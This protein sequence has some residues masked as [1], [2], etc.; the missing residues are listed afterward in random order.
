MNK[1]TQNNQIKLQNILKYYTEYRKNNYDD[2]IG[3]VI[4]NQRREE[5]QKEI[6]IELQ[7]LK[8]VKTAEKYMLLKDER[9]KIYKQIEN[10]VNKTY[11]YKEDKIEL[12]KINET[13]E[14]LCNL[15]EVIENKQL[16]LIDSEGVNRKFLED[17]NINVLTRLL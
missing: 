9:Y 7:K 8:V 11:E 16:L 12:K 14:S 10:F 13:I 1:L 3:I 6:R 5:K 17:H 15:L 2:N 4:E